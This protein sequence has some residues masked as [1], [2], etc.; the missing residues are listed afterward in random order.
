MPPAYGDS[1]GPMIVASQTYILLSSTGPAEMDGG[2]SRD[3]RVRDIG[4]GGEGMEGGANKSA[5]SFARRL[6]AMLK[7]QKQAL[8]LKCSCFCRKRLSWLSLGSSGSSEM[9]WKKGVAEWQSC[10]VFAAFISEFRRY[11]FCSLFE[12]VKKTKKD[13]RG[14]AQAVVRQLVLTN[15]SK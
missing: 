2:G 13:N 10:N 12:K 1:L 5:S 6:A 4:G 14:T 11:Y 9:P 7:S 8:V 15:G 3:L